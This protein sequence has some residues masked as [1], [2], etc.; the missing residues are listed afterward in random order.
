[1]LSIFDLLYHGCE[2]TILQ[3]ERNCC[4]I[5]SFAHI[6]CFFCSTFSFKANDIILS[7]GPVVVTWTS[8]KTGVIAALIV[9]PVNA[10]LVLLFRYAKPIPI[11]SPMTEYLEKQKQL[12]KQEKR[13]QKKLMKRNKRNA[14]ANNKDGEQKSTHIADEEKDPNMNNV[15]EEIVNEEEKAEKPTV[16][17]PIT[18][19]SSNKGEPP[20]VVHIDTRAKKKKFWLPHKAIYVGY[21]LAFVTVLK[22]M[23]CAL[24]R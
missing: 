10:V 5:L 17:L 20:K 15:E 14:A 6:D 18:I 12:E 19:P 22:N 13:E 3:N 11:K 21:A 1:M 24:S 2:H 7:I 8:L 16:S 4:R 23:K 9:A